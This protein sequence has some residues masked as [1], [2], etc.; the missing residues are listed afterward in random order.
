MQTG[1]GTTGPGRCGFR[2]RRG[3]TLIELL[4]VIAIISLLVGILVPVVSMAVRRGEDARCRARVAE[5]ADGCMAYFHETGYYP[6]QQY[7]DRLATTNP[8][9]P[10]QYT[11]SQWLS[12]TLFMDLSLAATNPDQVYPQDKYAPV[13]PADDLIDPK[14]TEGFTF[15]STQ[16]TFAFGTLSDR[17]S[18]PMPIL[19]YPARAGVSSGPNPTNQQQYKYFDNRLYMVTTPAPP[20]PDGEAQFRQFIWDFHSGQVRN[21]GA[22]LIIAAGLDRDYFTN[23]DVRYPA[24]QD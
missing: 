20:T 1:A 21:P 16:V 23:D 9:G 2:R 11:G 5:L 7:P 17:M 19:Y 6:G 24:W 18:R 22:F 8:P 15:G 4:V 14:H 12:R 3:F 13:R 10:P